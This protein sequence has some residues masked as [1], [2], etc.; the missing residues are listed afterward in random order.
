MD[1][2][3]DVEADRGLPT[4]SSYDPRPH[5]AEEV[6]DLPS[7]ADVFS[8]DD[9][10]VAPAAPAPVPRQQLP[11]ALILYEFC[12]DPDSM[13]G[14]V[15]AACGVQVIRLCSRDIGL[16]DDE[17]IDQLLDQVQSNAPPGLHGRT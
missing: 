9:A 14:Q 10:D 13:L 4:A 1:V 16:S 2:V 12:C 6:H 3:E 7:M 8:A 5:A 15:G 17:A 11:G